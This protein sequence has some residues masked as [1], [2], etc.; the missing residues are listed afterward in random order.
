MIRKTLLKLPSGIILDKKIDHLRLHIDG[1][2][3]V[4]KSVA[5]VDYPVVLF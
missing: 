5:D 1:S 2:V 3:F 4:F